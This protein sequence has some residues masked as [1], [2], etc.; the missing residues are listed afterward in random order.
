LLVSATN[1]RSALE[2]AQGTLPDLIII[3]S[4]LDDGDGAGFIQPLRDLL[5]K[6][7][8]PVILLTELGG[9]NDTLYRAE[10]VAT[11]YLQRP[12]SPPMLRTRIR[13]WLA[14][15][16]GATSTPVTVV[17]PP[18]LN[19]PALSVE[20]EDELAGDSLSQLL[21]SMPLFAPLTPEQRAELIARSTLVKFAAD[22]TIVRQEGGAALVYT[23]SSPVTFASSSPSWIVRFRCFWVNSVRAKSSASWQFC[24][25]ASGLPAW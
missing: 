14:R 19:E 24:A 12:F 6:P 4:K 9:E 3:N 10:S 15:T 23:P 8:L 11:D 25:S 22:H 2:M 16:I 7:D 18:R 13:A 5:D 21:S 20:I 1:G 17:V